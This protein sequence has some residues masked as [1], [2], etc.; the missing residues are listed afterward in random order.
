MEGENIIIDNQY[1]LQLLTDEFGDGILR[2]YEPDGI[3]TLEIKKEILI[4]VVQFIK[5]QSIK[6]NFLTDLCGIHYPER[7]GAELGVVY[8][9]HSFINNF[10]IRLKTFFSIEN[11]EVDSLT[12][13]YSAANWMERETFD[14]YGIIF[15]GHPNLVRILNMDEMTYFPM[16]KQ[17]QLEDATRED[18]DDSMFG[19]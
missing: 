10:R 3:L 17:Y 4:P 7:K 1:V 6:I 18:K 2:A 5:E 16:R 9:L 15:R 14:F 12:P 11:P 8:H 19:R 13:M